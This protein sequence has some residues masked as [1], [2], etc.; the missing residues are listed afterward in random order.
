MV[1]LGIPGELIINMNPSNFKFQSLLYFYIVNINIHL[2]LSF[3]SLS[4][5]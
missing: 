1:N 2:M 3:K 5:T 4:S